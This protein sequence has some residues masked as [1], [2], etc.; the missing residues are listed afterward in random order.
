MPPCLAT[1]LDRQNVICLADLQ[2][3][4]GDS[5]TG[6]IQGFDVL[7]IKFYIIK[8]QQWRERGARLGYI[9]YDPRI[10]SEDYQN[11]NAQEVLL[12]SLKLLHNKFCYC[13]LIN[14]NCSLI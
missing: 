3:I 5:L 11:K 4:V 2:S 10:S 7:D 12:L 13:V 9:F 14:S 1:V 8:S 6:T